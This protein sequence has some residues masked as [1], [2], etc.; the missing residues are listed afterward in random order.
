MD[1]S[2]EDLCLGMIEECNYDV[3][4]DIMLKSESNMNLIKSHEQSI[5]KARICRIIKTAQLRP[6]LGAVI[7]SSDEKRSV[8]GPTNL[9][10]VRELELRHAFFKRL[11]DTKKRDTVLILFFPVLTGLLMCEMTSMLAILFVIRFEEALQLMDRILDCAAT[12]RH[13]FALDPTPPYP[14]FDAR[15]LDRVIHR[16]RQKLIAALSPLDLAFLCLIPDLVDETAGLIGDDTETTYIG[17][18]DGEM[19]LQNGTMGV[20]HALIPDESH[21]M[22]L[23]EARFAGAVKVMQWDTGMKSEAPDWP[24]GRALEPLARVVRRTFAEK[25]PT[26]PQQHLDALEEAIADEDVNAG[27]R[28]AAIPEYWLIG[29]WLT[30]RDTTLEERPPIPQESWKE[31]FDWAATQDPSLAEP[32]VLPERD[33]PDSDDELRAFLSTAMDAWDTE[34]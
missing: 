33:E 16:A 15:G 24:A 8:L 32:E 30:T 3:I 29:R 14:G 28:V 26:L 7:S 11:L 1:D 27:R 34:T 31:W 4:Q 5:A 19:L 22:A 2:L 20:Y 23:L 9:E 25:L 18:I 17:G 12:I 6:P 10:V 21:T 13:E